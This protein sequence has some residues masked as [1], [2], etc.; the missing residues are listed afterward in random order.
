M[1][2]LLLTLSVASIAFLVL[3]LIYS[4]VDTMMYI[5]DSIAYGYIPNSNTPISVFENLGPG[6]KQT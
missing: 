1:N 2:N 5:K 3:F 6:Y 4:K